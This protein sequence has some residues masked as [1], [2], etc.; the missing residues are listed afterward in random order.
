MKF[1]TSKVPNSYR[2]VNKR[3]GELTVQT[4]GLTVFFF[5]PELP[6]TREIAFMLTIIHKSFYVRAVEEVFA[7]FI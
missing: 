2:R 4:H 7:S 5:M 3:K 6:L 1:R